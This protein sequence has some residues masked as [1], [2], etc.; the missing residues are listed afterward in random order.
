MLIQSKYF[1][2]HNSI[3]SIPITDYDEAILLIS[4]LRSNDK[5]LYGLRY[6]SMICTIVR[7]DPHILEF[8]LRHLIIGFSHIVIYDNNRIFSGHDIIIKNLLAPF[9]AAEVVT[10]VPWE[11]N[12]TDFLPNG[13]KNS[14]SKECLNKYGKNA[15]W[16]TVLDTDEYFYYEKENMTMHRLNDLLL[17]LENN[18]LCAISVY[19]TMMYGEGRILK[20]NKSLFQ[21]YSRICQIV[22]QTKILARLNYTIYDIPHSARCSVTNLTSKTW[23]SNKYSKIGIIH[24][25]SKSIQEFLL[26]GDQS[27][28]PYIRK[29]LATYDD[30][31]RICNK[32]ELIYAEDYRRIFLDSYAQL[33]K[34]SSLKLKYLLSPPGLNVKQ[35][36][37]YPLFI[38]LK[39]RCA[40]RQEFDNEKYL[41]INPDVKKLLDNG[42]FTDGLHH[43]MASFLTGIKGCWK[44]DSYSICE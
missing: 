32:I 17:E 6:R 28:P 18:S 19:W 26:K 37:D 8:I 44:T 11:Q 5:S 42:T 39:Y 23:P 22:G 12:S 7:N 21:S 13:N 30:A 40:K 20:Q 14:N 24:Y 4:R 9:I 27:I 38:Y 16:V 10:H 1:S 36:P 43:F 33:E 15:D 34:L 25:Y 29:P 31:G 41:N 3:S 35:M 2:I